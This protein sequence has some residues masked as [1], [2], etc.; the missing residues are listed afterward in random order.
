[1]L[2][3]DAYR[4]DIKGCCQ[5][6]QQLEYTAKLVALISSVQG[7]IRLEFNLSFLSYLNHIVLRFL[8]FFKHLFVSN[9]TG[10]ALSFMRGVKWLRKF[11]P[12]AKVESTTPKIVE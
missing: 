9:F 4:S 11:G 8:W 1:V 7:N 12:P 2:E 5:S 6:S 10:G 3:I